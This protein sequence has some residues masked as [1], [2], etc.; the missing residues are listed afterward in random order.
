MNI[1]I[2]TRDGELLG[3]AD[4][5][6]REGHTVKVMTTMETSGNGV[7]EKLDGSELYSAIKWCRF[8]LADEH[9]EED[10]YTKVAMY[11]K[12]V[13][14]SSHYTTLFNNDCIKEYA[15]CKKWKLGI[16]ETQAV[17]TIAEIFKIATDWQLPSMDIRYDRSWFNGDHR[18][19]MSWAT[20][21]IP[22]GK[23]VLLQKPIRGDIEVRVIGL[24][25]G[26][27]FLKPLF[28][29]T[30]GNGAVGNCIVSPIKDDNNLV[31][32]NLILLEQWLRIVDYRGPVSAWLTLEDDR[33]YLREIKVGFTYPDIYAILEGLQAPIGTLF[34]AL[35]FGIET[36]LE[37]KGK[38]FAAVETTADR[39]ND[40]VGAPIIELEDTEKLCHIFP[41]GIMKSDLEKEEY[42]VSGEGEVVYTATCYSETINEARKRVTRTI[43]NTPF[44][45]MKFN[46]QVNIPAT[47]PF[48]ILKERNYL[49]A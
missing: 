7:Y 36:E 37:T 9:N 48:G 39:V 11:N 19:F 41:I 16:P 43:N 6:V 22:P 29:T 10:F 44:P 45:T 42:F 17:S 13:I 20:M 30:M 23:T 5:L 26:Q 31:N 47:Y 49:N 40:L 12:P 28:V 21:K 32:Q 24:F 8:I 15:V 35:A 4:R 3:I 38:Y 18:S 27:N 2:M 34:N 46:P 25:N 1:L 33:I 14:G